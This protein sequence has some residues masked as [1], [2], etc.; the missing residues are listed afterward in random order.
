MSRLIRFTVRTAVMYGIF[1]YLEK[2]PI[3]LR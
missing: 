2:N 3:K 1:E